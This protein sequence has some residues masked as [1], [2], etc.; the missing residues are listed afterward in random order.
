MWRQGRKA[1]RPFP[2]VPGENF[3][4]SL[5]EPDATRVPGLEVIRPE[6]PYSASSPARSVAG[7]DTCS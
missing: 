1:I 5:A 4:T 2:A 6:S 3:V 7:A